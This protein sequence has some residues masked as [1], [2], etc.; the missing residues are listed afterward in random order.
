MTTGDF[1]GDGLADL[2]T[3][4]LASNDVSVLLG[5]GD[6][7]FADQQKFPVG[8]QPRSVTTG[9][10]NGDGQTDLVTSNGISDDVS[11]LL[12]NG[13]GTFAGQ[14]TFAAG[15]NPG[16]VTT[17][18]FNGDG[19]SDL[20]VVNNVTL[21][22]YDFYGTVTVLL[23]GG[24]GTFAPPHN[25]NVLLGTGH[26]TTG[27]FNGD[28]MTDL[29]TG[30]SGYSSGVPSGRVSVR[31]GNGD[32]T[33]SFVQAFPAGS[34]AGPIASDD[35]N[36]DGLTDLV[37]VSNHFFYGD[38]TVA[39]GNGDGT[40]TPQNFYAGVDAGPVATGDFNG[41]GMADVAIGGILNYD[42]QRVVSVL[43]SNGDG[44]FVRQEALVDSDATSITTG[45][46]NGDGLTDIATANPSSDV[47]R[48]L[49]NQCGSG[50]ATV[51][52]SEFT[53]FRG[54]QLD[55]TLV[56]ALESDD[57]RLRFNPGFITNSTEA[58]VWLIF[59][60]A[61]A[62]DSPSS[63]EISVESQAGTPGLTGALEAFNW[64][65]NAYEIV[66]V[67]AASFNTDTVVSV[68]VSSD[69]SNYVQTGSGAVRSRIGWRQTG[70]TINFPW[71]VRLDQMVWTVN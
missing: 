25:F 30:S 8:V 53:V 11:V 48:V 7:T 22:S 3:A 55:G 42:F 69:I 32:G 2:A 28:G 41:D 60:A 35:F 31:L 29:A 15:G 49:L 5:N 61:L 39:M 44:T 56:D 46:F 33:F 34:G 20:V 4:N 45:D 51:E 66:D 36:G 52:P 19:L 47:A 9:D 26:V 21:G 71:E 1:N 38:A 10:F 43:L 63:L 50:V 58:P 16:M 59:D 23:A 27:D 57:S 65:S 18:D 62:S 54:I 24:G 6:G 13:D 40:F 67:S 68:D 37:T 70:F 12:G 64:G 14:Q 17:G